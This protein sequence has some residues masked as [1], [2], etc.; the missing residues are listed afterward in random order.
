MNGVRPIA[1][2]AENWRYWRHTAVSMLAYTSL[3]K[4]ENSLDCVVLWKRNECSFFGS[5]AQDF[6][7][8]CVLSTR[9]F[10]YWLYCL[11][12]TLSQINL[13][14]KCDITQQRSLIC[15]KQIALLDGL[16]VWP[17]QLYNIA[18]TMQ[19]NINLIS[20]TPYDNYCVRP[21]GF[22]V[23]LHMPWAGVQCMPMLLSSRP[24]QAPQGLRCR[25]QRTL[26]IGN[27]NLGS[28]LL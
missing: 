6:S 26:M 3:L 7:C 27:S 25:R 15:P 22:R 20:S 24:A 10:S 17:L 1:E 2:L 18:S 8:L 14:W 5:A 11:S 19:I 28:K 13:I 21:M 23:H 4:S 9:L 16:S 12:C